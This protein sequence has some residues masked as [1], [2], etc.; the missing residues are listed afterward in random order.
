MP[1]TAKQSRFV[2]EYL[3]D[4]NATQAA[5]RSGYSEKTARSIGQENLTKPA[6][7]AAIQKAGA[8]IS[9][10]ALVTTKMVVEGLLTEARR[11]DASATHG[12]RVSAWSQLSKYTGGFADRSEVKV[13][14]S[15][16]DALAAL[17]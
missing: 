16:E 4:M 11:D 1:L 9:E 2:E 3:K 5:I 7:A 8:A 17:K 6:I 15:H 13:N 12:A 14:V 10:E